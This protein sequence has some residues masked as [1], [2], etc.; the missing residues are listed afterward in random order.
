VLRASGR[1]EPSDPGS[2]RA[3]LL[4]FDAKLRLT[5]GILAGID[6][7][8]RGPLAGPLIAAAVCLPPDTDLPEVDDSKRLTDAARRRA[9]PRILETCLGHGVGIVEASEIDARGMSAAVREAFERAAAACSLSCPS[10]PLVY[11]VDGL[12]VRGLSFQAHFVV[13]GDRCSLSAAAASVIAKVTRDDLMLDAHR[14]WPQY[15]FSA[16]KGYGS[17]AHLRAIDRFGPCPIHRMSFHPLSSPGL[18]DELD[19]R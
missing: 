4:E 6:E 2:G 12:P 3:N 10:A 5:W 16:N 15:G 9:L 7:A 17:P 8:G 1:R 14:K 19:I 18:F 13:K 11:I